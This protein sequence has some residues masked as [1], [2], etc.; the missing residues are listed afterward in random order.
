MDIK[1]LFAFYPLFVSYNHGIALLSS[2]CG[3]FG[4]KS[5]IYLLDNVEKF[6]KYL[7]NNSVNCICFSCVTK[8]DYNLSLAFM[9]VAKQKGIVIMLGGVYPRLITS[10]G[11][12]VD[13]VC[14]GEGEMLPLFFTKGYKDIF[15]SIQY[16]DD[17]N[18]LPLPDYEI[19]KNIP[20]DRVLPFG[21]WKKPLPYSSSRGCPFRC[22]FCQVSCQSPGVRIRAKVNSDLNRIVGAYKPDVIHFL[23]ELIPYYNEHWQ[24]SWGEFKHPFVSYIRADITES[25]LVWL[26]DHGLSGCFFGIES[27]N[28]RYRNEILKKN[29][30]DKQIEKTVSMLK[31]MNIPFMASYMRGMPGESWEMQAETV[32]LSR[33]L[34]GNP[35]FYSYENII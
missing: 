25:Q 4:I 15:E 22:S 2:L 6:G 20:Y 17:L 31:E 34:G 27:G 18:N 23:D 11:A 16:Y 32:S 28:E 33:R 1:I 14:R 5:D 24:E 9:D 26:K 7:D 12:P 3:A 13:L 10:L 21:N 19:F 8:Y 35:V 29:L 30:S